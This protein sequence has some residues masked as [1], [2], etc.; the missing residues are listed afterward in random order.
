MR[1]VS[2][3]VA[4]LACFVST[5]NVSTVLGHT[6]G[7]KSGDY[8]RYDISI[9]GSVYSDS[10]K[11]S[12]KLNIQSVTCPH[13]NGT[14]E[15]NVLGYSV[16]PQ[17]EPFTLDISTGN[18]IYGGYIIPANLTVGSIVP[19]EGITVQSIVDWR[20]RKAIQAN[21]SSPFSGLEGQITWDQ[22]TGVLLEAKSSAVEFT[23][24]VVL[25]DTNI[26][27]MGFSVGWWIWIIIIVVIVA[28]LAVVVLMLRRKKTAGT[29]F[30]PQAPPPPPP[31]S[32]AT[33]STCP[34]CGGSLTYIG[35]Y[36]K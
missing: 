25:A 28:V 33:A 26:W 12:I 9:L 18:G 6:C 13:I 16:T 22:L 8:V 5:G 15:A 17:P 24:S 27:S 21:A 20:G 30:S 35:Q 3:F 23:Y 11:G 1:K 29:P 19:G 2:I 14:Y 36:Q 7:V 4:L 34:T 31:P 32:P 10:I